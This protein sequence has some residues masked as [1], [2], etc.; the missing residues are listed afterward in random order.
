[1]E[2]GTLCVHTLPIS[3]GLRLEQY[4]KLEATAMLCLFKVGH[5]CLL[6]FASGCICLSVRM[7]MDIPLWNVGFHL[8]DL[9]SRTSGFCWEELLPPQS[10]TG[11]FSV[12][13]EVGEDFSMTLGRV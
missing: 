10:R 8:A 4:D 2:V 13:P 11:K 1:M 12:L 3:D 7:V 9:I 5:L 6:A